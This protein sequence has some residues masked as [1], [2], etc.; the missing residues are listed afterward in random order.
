MGN[1]QYGAFSYK[2]GFAINPLKFLLGLA[3]EAKI[4]GVKIF[5]KSKVSKI[6]KR[7]GKFN[8][9]S[10]GHIITANKIVMAT[11]GFYQDDLFP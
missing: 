6:E 10:N 1:E 8:I 3:K 7:S 5:Q 4:S 11:N 9:I 2:P